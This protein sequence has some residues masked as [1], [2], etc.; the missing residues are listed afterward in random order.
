MQATQGQ[1]EPDDTR[2]SRRLKLKRYGYP[3]LLFVYSYRFPWRVLLNGE[4]MFAGTDMG[5]ST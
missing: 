5:R 1:S 4:G 2:L 3:F